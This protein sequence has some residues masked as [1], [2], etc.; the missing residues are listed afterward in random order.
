MRYALNIYAESGSCH[1]HK[2]FK[3]LLEM[4]S[5]RY[6]WQSLSHSKST[7]SRSGNQ[8]FEQCLCVHKEAIWAHFEP[9]HDAY[10]QS[11]Y[12]ETNSVHIPI[13]AYSQFCIHIHMIQLMSIV[14]QHKSPYHIHRLI[15]VLMQIKFIRDFKCISGKAEINLP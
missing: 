3:L 4:N 9:T 7:C 5:T 13:F 6:F 15:C 1:G 14:I 10:R 11:L 12:Q 8:T 2:A